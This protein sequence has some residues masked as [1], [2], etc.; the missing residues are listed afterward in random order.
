MTAIGIV[1]LGA[2]GSRIASRWRNAAGSTPRWLR[3]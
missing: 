1:G 2:M 3:R